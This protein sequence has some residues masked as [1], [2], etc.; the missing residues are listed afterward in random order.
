[1][2]GKRQPGHCH[3]GMTATP[4][5]VPGGPPVDVA[6]RGHLVAAQPPKR[7]L[8]RA[9]LA[10]TASVV[11]GV[12]L[13]ALGVSAVI[14]F[15]DFMRP[16][17]SGEQYFGI[18][19]IDLAGGPEFDESSLFPFGD[20]TKNGGYAPGDSGQRFV[21]LEHPRPGFYATLTLNAELVELVNPPRDTDGDGPLDTPEPPPADFSALGDISVEVARCPLAGFD[22]ET[23]ECETG[24][25]V[26]LPPL[27]LD[28]FQR[29][30]AWRGPLTAG[31]PTII[32][33]S[34]QVSSDPA[35]GDRLQGTLASVRFAWTLQQNE[36]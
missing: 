8:R 31:P 27:P 17:N 2:A 5:A 24:W 32:R 36:G 11:S 23:K 12:L 7:K 14:F 6:T 18:D 9:G 35:S 15:E 16:N 22:A 28:R 33:L 29:V 10:R 30:S 26:V 4:A 20:P 21:L 13:L 34:Y 25:D 3:G 19:T 1:M